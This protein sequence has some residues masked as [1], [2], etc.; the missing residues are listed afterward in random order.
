M[1]V[2]RTNHHENPGSSGSSREEGG[3][4]E[5][6]QEVDAEEGGLTTGAR[7]SHLTI[8]DSLPFNTHEPVR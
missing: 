3:G 1:T 2:Y 8:G 4:L 6:E 5:L 7:R